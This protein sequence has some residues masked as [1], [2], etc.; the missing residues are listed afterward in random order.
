MTR[1]PTYEE[2]EQTVKR[3]ET[4][5]N[6]RKPSEDALRETESTFR[7]LLNAPTDVAWVVDTEGLVV[8]SFMT[9]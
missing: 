7:T 3:L 8:D 2:L 4:E 1:K 5:A 6:T 9:A